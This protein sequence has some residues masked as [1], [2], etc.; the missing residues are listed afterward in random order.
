MY[1]QCLFS[2]AGLGRCGRCWTWS[3][4]PTR[5]SQSC[6]PF[7][8]RIGARLEGASAHLHHRP[9]EPGSVRPAP[10]RTH[11]EQVTIEHHTTHRNHKPLHIYMLLFLG[12]FRVWDFTK[13]TSAVVG[14]LH[15]LPGGLNPWGL[16]SGHI[17]VGLKF[18]PTWLPT[19]P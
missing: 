2:L 10:H 12:L 17:G 3:L 6:C 15:S 4:K 9:G 11:T 1:S 19:C 8:P 18:D 7:S 14:G 16:P 13:K 5:P